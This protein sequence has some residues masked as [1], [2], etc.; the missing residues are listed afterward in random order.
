MAQRLAVDR[1]GR[2]G[3]ERM[4]PA[5]PRG[6]IAIILGL[7][8]VSTACQDSTTNPPVTP[9]RQ[10]VVSGRAE[11]GSTVRFG[12]EAAGGSAVVPARDSIVSL[13]VTPADAAT[14]MADSAQ[15][16]ATGT[17][18][19]SATLADQTVL[20][21][22]VLV[23]AP[24]TVVFEG[25]ERTAG[26]DI[27]KIA[28]DGGDLTRLTFNAADDIQPS[29]AGEVVVFVSYRDRNGEL[30]SIRLDGTGEQRLTNTRANETLPAVSPDGSKLAYANDATGV[31]KVW[32][33]ARDLSGAAALS[34]STFSSPASIETS[35]AWKSSS[36]QLM[37]VATA[38]PAGR[39][40]LFTAPPTSG[41]VPTIVPS[42]GSTGAEFEPAWSPDGKRIAFALLVNGTTQ[43][44]VR[45][46]PTSATTQLTSGTT[47]SGQPAWLPDGRLIFVRFLSS[48]SQELAWLDLSQPSV[49]HT[50]S[51]TG[52][53]AQHPSPVRP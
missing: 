4:M 35:P 17:L 33:A 38:G 36:D 1:V 37:F 46:L 11:R 40:S 50:I 3:G 51:I 45:D 16:V 42:S 27:Y 34:S 25:L 20:T 18:Q 22:T 12:V 30:Y 43:I 24:P 32:I 10:L 7:T 47:S 52:L 39:A 9:E 8:L 41:T 48:T 53:A 26:R 15:L 2:R 44:A 28:L 29:V 21:T 5:A 6:A 13:V 14:V 31:T 19:V 49:V 23:A